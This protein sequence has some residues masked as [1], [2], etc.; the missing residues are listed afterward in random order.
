MLVL[1]RTPRRKHYHRD[2]IVITVVD[3]RGDK[4]RLGIAA[5]IEISVYRQEVHEA[6]QR[7]IG[8]RADWTPRR[9]P[10][11]TP[12]SA[13]SDATKSPRTDDI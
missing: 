8:R 1:S 11:R 2:D 5:P 12:Q 4:V 10:A 9:P 7:E 3:I 13:G 6:I